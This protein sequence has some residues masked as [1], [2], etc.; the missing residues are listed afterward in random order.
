M[1]ISN[2]LVLIQFTIT[3]M[4]ITSTLIVFQQ[5]RYFNT[6]D[7]GFE[8]DAIINVYLPDNTPSSLSSFRNQLISNTA[9]AQV[10]YSSTP[11]LRLKQGP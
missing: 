1:R 11:T 4:L 10:S 6:V 5:I 8:K 3:I 7:L 2:A 9:I